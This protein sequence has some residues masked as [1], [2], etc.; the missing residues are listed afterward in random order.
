MRIKLKSVRLEKGLKDVDSLAGK[1]GISASYYYKIEKGSRNPGIDL[2]KK[3]ADELD[4]T[5]DDLFLNPD[6]DTSSND[7]V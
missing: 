4:H 6:L 2:A 1:I 3:I 5:V 7:V